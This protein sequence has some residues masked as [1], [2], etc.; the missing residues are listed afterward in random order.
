[1]SKPEIIRF[2]RFQ[3]VTGKHLATA[4]IEPSKRAEGWK[5]IHNAKRIARRLKLDNRSL[6][7]L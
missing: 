4:F 1:M 5:L 3:I 2:L 7:Q 6:P